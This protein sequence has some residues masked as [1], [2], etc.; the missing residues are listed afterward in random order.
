MSHPTLLVSRATALLFA[1]AALIGTVAVSAQTIFT[2][3]GIGASTLSSPHADV[4]ATGGP[5]Y[6]NTGP[7]TNNIQGVTFGNSFSMSPTGPSD[8]GT[9]DNTFRISGAISGDAI[10]AGTLIGISYNFGLA[11]NN[12]VAIPGPVTWTLTLQDSVN[13]TAQVIATNSF[14]GTDS[15]TFV[16]T[17]AN[18]QFTSGVSS[19]ATFLA[20]LEVTYTGTNPMS[21]PVV[22]GTMLTTGYGQEGITIGASAIPEPSTYAA[23]AGAAMLGLAVWSRRR[24]PVTGA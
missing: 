8:F 9:F 22:T 14:S 10:T 15:A 23:I 1:A 12:L 4:S 11:R 5:L 2:A 3:N 6:N 7:V 20:I 24:R 18:Y 21:P 19:G 16:G 13:T 17:G